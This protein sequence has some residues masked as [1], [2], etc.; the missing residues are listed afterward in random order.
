MT[1]G[2]FLFHHFVLVE[3]LKAVG[4]PVSWS[5]TS[6]LDLQEAVIITASWNFHILTGSRLNCRCIIPIYWSQEGLNQLPKHLVK[7]SEQHAL[8]DSVSTSRNCVNKTRTCFP[9]ITSVLSM[10]TLSDQNE[11]ISILHAFNWKY[12]VDPGGFGVAS[13]CECYHLILLELLLA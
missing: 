7:Y 1:L 10:P 2:D 3:S 12:M 11:W 9:R 4:N 8:H 13:I 5:Q 6:W